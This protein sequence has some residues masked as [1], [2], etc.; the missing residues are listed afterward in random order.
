MPIGDEKLRFLFI[1]LIRFKVWV[2]T[3]DYDKSSG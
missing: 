3:G 2:E 1:N